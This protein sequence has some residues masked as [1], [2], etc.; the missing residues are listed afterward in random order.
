MVLTKLHEGNE[1]LKQKGRKFIRLTNFAKGYNGKK[2]GKST[3][4]PEFN[5]DTQI[6]FNQPINNVV[7]WAQKHFKRNIARREFLICQFFEIMRNLAKFGY[8]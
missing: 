2:N 8:I 6:F 5:R 7:K 3:C 4:S 1:V